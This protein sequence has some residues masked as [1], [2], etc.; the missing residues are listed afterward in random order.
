MGTE[1]IF[2]IA[3]AAAVLIMAGYYMKR[4]RKLLS[5]IFGSL[6]GIAA[7]FAVNSYG[8]LI[9]ADL[10]LNLFNVCGSSVLGVPFVICV[11]VLNI[12]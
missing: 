3:C 12:L 10:P 5:F 4:R 1:M 2:N 8:Y 7:L 9:G 6:T 11:T